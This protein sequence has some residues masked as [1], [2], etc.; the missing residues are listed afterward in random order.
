[1]RREV[2]CEGDGSKGSKF[3]RI[4][5][6]FEVSLKFADFGF[7]YGLAV[8]LICVVVVVVLMDRF[9]GIELLKGFHF[10]HDRGWVAWILTVFLHL[11][12]QSL[13]CF[14]FRAIVL[15]VKND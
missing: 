10:R 8:A 13:N 11:L 6:V 3:G 2:F 4:D 14:E 9:G 5:V 12:Q 1:M 15:V 7:D